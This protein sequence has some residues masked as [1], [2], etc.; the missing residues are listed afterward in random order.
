MIFFDIEFY[1]PPEDRLSSN[2][3]LVYNP[4]NVLHK[5]IGG[6]FVA[7]EIM[8]HTPSE[9]RSFWIWDYEDDEGRLLEAIT[10]FFIQQWDSDQS[11]KVVVMKKR[12]RDLLVCGFRVD[13]DLSALYVRSTLHKIKTPPRLY[14]I[15]CKCKSIDLAEVGTMLFNDNPIFYPVTATD[16][17]EKIGIPAEP[18]DPGRA[19]WGWYDEK[20]YQKIITRNRQE[21]MDT[22]MIYEGL[23]Q[24]RTKEK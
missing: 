9:P 21:V 17:A 13:S 15:F 7:K 20:Q 5:L 2:G 6:T 10:E 4:A 19:I 14:E 23:Q 3:S 1:V 22:L 11:E 12:I 16:L 24:N 18:K 8:S